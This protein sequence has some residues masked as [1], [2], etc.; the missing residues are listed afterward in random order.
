M[1]G[2]HMWFPGMALTK[3]KMY[4]SNCSKKKKKE[5]EKIEYSYLKTGPKQLSD[6]C[7]NI[8]TKSSEVF[9][10]QGWY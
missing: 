3:V 10:R 1:A 6:N 2:V 5:K 8:N 4:G 7:Y 9:D